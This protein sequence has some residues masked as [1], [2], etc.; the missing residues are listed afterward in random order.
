MSYIEDIYKVVGV[1][2]YKGCL[3]YPEE[4]R[5]RWSQHFFN[6]LQEAKDYLDTQFKKLFNQ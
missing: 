2:R 1:V 6:T 3:I 4:G 5:F